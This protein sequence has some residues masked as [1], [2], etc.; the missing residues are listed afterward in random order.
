V[1]KGEREKAK[2]YTK[3]ETSNS[4]R[5]FKIKDKSKKTKVWIKTKDKRRKGMME[6]WIDGIMEEGLRDLLNVNFEP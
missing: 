6:C 2:D 3:R 4:K 5:W 1:E